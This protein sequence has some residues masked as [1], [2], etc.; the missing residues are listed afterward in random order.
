MGFRSD[1]P[2]LLRI[3]STVRLPLL[4]LLCY[5]TSLSQEA[6]AKRHRLK[7]EL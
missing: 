1:M 4:Q 5:A 6:L 7:G 3:L 2:L